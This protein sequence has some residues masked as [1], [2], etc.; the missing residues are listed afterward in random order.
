MRKLLFGLLLFQVIQLYSQQKEIK[1]GDISQ[2]EISMTSYEKDKDAKAVV[3]YDKGNSHFYDNDGGFDIRFT[4]HKR[5]KIFDKSAE[6]HTEVTIPY[7][8]DGFGK[9]EVVKDI[10]ATTYNYENGSVEF[11]KLDMDN[12]YDEQLSEKYYQK[13]FVFPDVQNGAILELQYTLETPFHFN[14]PDWT[15]QN[16]IPTVYS[17]YE[18][19]MIPFYEYVYIANGISEFDVQKAEA[20]ME[21][22]SWSIV[23]FQDM[24]YT[25]ALNDVPAFEEQP[26]IA[27]AND[28]IAKIDFQLAKV[29]RPDG[30][31][32]N[33]IS[34]WEALNLELLKH[35]RFGLYIK[36]SKKFAKK[37]LEEKLIINDLNESERAKKIIH[38]V[39]TNFAWNGRNSKYASQ[40]PKEFQTKK[41]GNAADINLFMIAL[42]NESDIAAHPMIL[43]TREHG[44][45]LSDYPF[46][47]FTNY[48]LAHVNIGLG[49]LA[50]GTE[51]LLPY[52]RIPT[53]CLN[54][55]ALVVNKD[56]V[57]FWVSL[58][59]NTVSLEK[60]AIFLSLNEES[61]DVKTK[62]S[63]QS[64]E[65][66]SYAYRSKFNND[67]IKI[68][69]YYT[70]KIG[71]INKIKTINYMKKL[72]NP[73]NMF[74]VGNWETEKLGNNIVMKPFLNLPMTANKL[75]QKTRTYPVDFVYLWN[76]EFESILDIPAS[77][78]ITS[79][80][81]PYAV[82]NDLVEI[83]LNY[84]FENNI[85]NSKGY[86]KF[87]K[88]WYAPN[89]YPQ[90]KD[91]FDQIVKRFNQEVLIDIK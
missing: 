76:D 63:V 70:N 88:A 6:E 89:E 29:N 68:K 61:F 48:V 73:Y 78:T 52:N 28:Y 90:I 10:M 19:G 79:L 64:T 74:M 55:I 54:Y 81:E 82:D 1:F 25:Y 21:R 24:V 17:A 53:R 60:K 40:T 12:V 36:G 30:S 65:Y 22:R 75:D 67:T 16:S 20:K 13:K 34:T 50:D 59:N 39:K 87:K 69:K 91:Y 45:L 46:D 58:E 26:Y 14:L 85:L 27:S 56:K 38:Y 71:S 51:E 66:E 72:S 35:K 15:F 23:E 80:P 5:V 84:T 77:F 49:I 32:K 18:V 42:L 83:Y 11:V 44:R 86:Y 57:A 8:K 43:S 3:L 33:F 4:R 62:V 9:T 7:Y 41:T 37:I 47:H 31:K 2:D